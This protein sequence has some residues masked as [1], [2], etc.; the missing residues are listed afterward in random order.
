MLSPRVGSSHLWGLP[1]P[2]AA[3]LF[4]SPN[5][6]GPQRQSLQAPAVLCPASWGFHGATT[7]WGVPEPGPP[8]LP[9]PLGTQVSGQLGG[10][11][12]NVGRW[13]RSR[14]PP[15]SPQLPA[16]RAPLWGLN[17]VS[18]LPPPPTHCGPL[19]RGARAAL[20]RR[21]PGR[22]HGS[23]RPAPSPGIGLRTPAATHCPRSHKA[24]LVPR[25]QAAVPL[26]RGAFV[27][28]PSRRA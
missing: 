13:A 2:P 4:F 3:P 18:N 26:S 16:D 20:G 15:P 11:Q 8:S 7:S 22:P 19:R 1:A 17:T 23:Q 14:A 9:P 24:A 12:G 5:I 28:L 27:H 6:Q 21:R 25:P 10:K